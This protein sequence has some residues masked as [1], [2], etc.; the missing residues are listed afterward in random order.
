[1]AH[2]TPPTSPT[3]A[4]AHLRMDL[5]EHDGLVTAARYA[6]LLS[7]GRCTVQDIPA[8]VREMLETLQL[9]PEQVG[10]VAVV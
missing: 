8:F 1:M 2:S 3:H 10:G 7:Q 4:L 5:H 6:Q 9:T